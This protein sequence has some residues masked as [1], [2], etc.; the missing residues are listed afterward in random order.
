VERRC[1]GKKGAVMGR[2][3]LLWEERRCYGKKGAVMGRKEKFIKL[4]TA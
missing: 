3:A 1:Y 4:H 2:K